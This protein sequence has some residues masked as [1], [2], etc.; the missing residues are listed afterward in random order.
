LNTEQ[1]KI[2]IATE[3]EKIRYVLLNTEQQ[4]IE[5][6]I[7]TKYEKYRDDQMNTGF[8]AALV[9]GFALTNSWEMDINSD[10]KL[11]ST[12]GLTSYTLA[13]LAVHGCTFSALVS[14]ILYRALTGVKSPLGGVQLVERRYIRVIVKLPW[15]MVRI[16]S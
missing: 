7:E 13:I 5:I 12:T 14:A 10:E 3:D 4:K 6:E 15:Y 1:R 9:G 11:V 8:I 16:R 2:V